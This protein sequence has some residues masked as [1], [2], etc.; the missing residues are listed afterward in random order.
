MGIVIQ[1]DMNNEMIK[2]QIEVQEDK[3]EVVMNKN[4]SEFYGEDE[5]DIGNEWNYNNE[6]EQN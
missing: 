5:V 6:D 3:K 2:L 1:K 4:N